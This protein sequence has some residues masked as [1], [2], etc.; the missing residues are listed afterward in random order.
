[1]VW[2]TSFLA[3]DQFLTGKLHRTPWPRIVGDGY[4]VVTCGVVTMRTQHLIPPPSPSFYHFLCQRPNQ[5]QKNTILKMQENLILVGD[6]PIRCTGAD[7]YTSSREIFLIQFASILYA[8]TKRM[9]GGFLPA[10]RSLFLMAQN[11]HFSK[12]IVFQWWKNFES[13]VFPTKTDF[14][15]TGTLPDHTSGSKVVQH[16]T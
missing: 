8:A 10:R 11:G 12:N 5:R 9:V 7:G 6:N 13:L 4:P 2:K 3:F 14:H 1:M 15:H 16:T